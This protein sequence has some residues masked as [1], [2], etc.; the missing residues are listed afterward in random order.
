MLSIKKIYTFCQI[1]WKVLKKHKTN[2]SN[3][4]FFSIKYVLVHGGMI[5]MGKG[6]SFINEYGI[7][8]V[9]F[10]R[11]SGQITWFFFATYGKIQKKRVK[12]CKHKLLD[13]GISWQIEWR[14]EAERCQ[15][16][17]PRELI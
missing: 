9:L 11:T 5:G 16:D 15:F 3:E 12:I 13:G 8:R 2:T 7:F 1:S 14:L 6:T 10:A 17:I 4:K